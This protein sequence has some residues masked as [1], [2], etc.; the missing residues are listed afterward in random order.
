[1][2]PSDARKAATFV[3]FLVE[4]RQIPNLGAAVA[5]AASIMYGA[6]RAAT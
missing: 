6:S 4:E 5:T 1:M 3:A 2:I